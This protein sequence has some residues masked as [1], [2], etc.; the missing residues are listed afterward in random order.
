MLNIMES[1][2]AAKLV[3]SGDGTVGSDLTNDVKDAL[4]D[5]FA[6]VAWKNNSGQQY[7][8]ALQSALYPAAT[9]QN[10]EAK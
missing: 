8:S 5:C 4:L 6:N 3:K 7:Y 1:L 10:E 9:Q 2:I